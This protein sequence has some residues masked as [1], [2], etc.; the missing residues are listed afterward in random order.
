MRSDKEKALLRGMLSSTADF[1]QQYRDPYTTHIGLHPL[2]WSNNE[3]LALP[4]I[5]DA[6]ILSCSKKD[7]KGIL[8]TMYKMFSSSITVA[9]KS[10]TCE[11]SGKSGPRM[12]ILD[13]QPIFFSSPTQCSCWENYISMLKTLN[14]RQF[15]FY[16]WGWGSVLHP[17]TW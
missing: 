3:L 6:F 5:H 9:Q 15:A 17:V 12:A 4:I 7:H 10:C 16:V 2:C 8:Y 1:T 13:I 14:H 11:R